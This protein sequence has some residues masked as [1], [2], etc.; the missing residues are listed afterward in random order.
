MAPSPAGMNFEPSQELELIKSQIDQFIEQEIEPIE[1]ENEDLLGEHAE[2]NAL[3]SNGRVSD[4][5]I[6]VHDEIIRKSAGA[7]FYAMQYPETVGGGGLDLLE[8]LLVLEHIYDRHPHGFHRNIVSG[9]SLPTEMQDDDYQR[10]EYLQP[11]LNGEEM[12]AIAI[13][14]PDHGS[15]VT[16]MDTTAE[17]EGDSW[18]LN[19]TKCYITDAVFADSVLVVART[20]G[21]DGD[22]TGITA[23]IV[24]AENPGLELGRIHRPMG[25][26]DE[27]AGALSTIHFNDCRVPNEQLVGEE[28][29]G[30]VKALDTIGEIRLRI[31]ARAVGRA[32]WMF[33][34]CVDYACDRTVFGDSLGTNQFIKGKLAEL[35]T[36]IE[37]VRWLYRRAAWRYDRGEGQRWEQSAAKLRGGQLWNK[38][39][40]IGVQIHGGAGYM[41]S[42]P[43][44]LEYRNARATRIYDGTEEVHKLNIADHFL[45]D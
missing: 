23:F 39:A 4:E 3:D 10:E 17:H 41:R 42:L 19:G 21:D 12:F 26:L 9:L 31:P 33:N 35:R 11:Y 14:E 2:R 30:L 5:Y 22:S 38:A 8:F 37:Q 15:D 32:Q 24:D 28:G 7:G 29:L 6:A 20:S 36:D 44:E 43:F 45:E 40:D 16:W 27:G 13:T 34:E 25:G 18:I 1:A